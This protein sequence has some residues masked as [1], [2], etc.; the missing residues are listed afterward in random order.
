MKFKRFIGCFFISLLTFILTFAHCNDVRAEYPD[1]PI[2]YII[3]F[4][5]GGISDTTARLQQSHLEKILGVSV[6]VV[7]KPGGG[8]AVAWSEFQRT[9]KPDGYTIIGINIPHIIGQPIQR[10]DAGYTTEGWEPIIWFHSTPVALI[11]SKESDIK[12]LQ[13]FVNKAKAKP[14]VITVAGSGSNSGTHLELLRFQKMAGIETTYI[15][16]TGT[17]ALIPAIMGRHVDS[18][19]DYSMVSIQYRD[20]LRTLAVATNERLTALPD[21]PTFKE[22]GYDLVGGAY[23]GIAVPKGTPRDVVEKLTNAFVKTN[24]LI[25]QEQRDMGFEVTYYTGAQAQELLEKMES[26]YKGLIQNIKK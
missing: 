17:G 11:V 5:P 3:P 7:H 25:A 20:K 16:Y 2:T 8:G 21:T 6:N 15:P 19:M 23:R 9:A 13:D 12:T 26:E 10:K 24:E 1:K 14:K 18:T 22:Q 4:N